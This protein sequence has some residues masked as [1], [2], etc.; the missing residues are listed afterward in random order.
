MVTCAIIACKNCRQMKR[1]GKYWLTAKN[2]AQNRKWLHAKIP[3][4]TI[5][6]SQQHLQDNSA[7]DV[8][9]ALTLIQSL[10]RGR[11]A[12]NANY[13]ATEQQR[14]VI[15]EV[16]ST[17]ALWAVLAE[18]RRKEKQDSLDSQQARQDQMNNVSAKL[19]PY[20]LRHSQRPND[21]NFKLTP[22][23][24]YK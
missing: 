4:V 16:K 12:Q 15:N 20:C 21:T 1:V 8:E 11:G 19:M 23:K 7:S 9:A 5:A 10:I 3:H 2:P 6:L 18:T 13:E 22:Y 14:D 17:H 24:Y